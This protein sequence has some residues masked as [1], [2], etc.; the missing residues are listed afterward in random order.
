MWKNISRIHKIKQLKKEN[1]SEVG[2][3]RN[4]LKFLEIC[5]WIWKQVLLTIWRPL[6]LLVPENYGK[7]PGK[8]W[9]CFCQLVNYQDWFCQLLELFW[10][11]LGLLPTTYFF[12][13]MLK[14]SLR[15]MN[16]SPDNST[17]PLVVSIWTCWALQLQEIEQ[18]F[19]RKHGNLVLFDNPNITR[20]IG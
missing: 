16:T 18:F 10:Q 3:D 12:I 19:L 7:A 8:F 13:G 17:S 9:D 20:R 4:N 5:F 14:E 2:H 15:F 6:V 11:L 1:C